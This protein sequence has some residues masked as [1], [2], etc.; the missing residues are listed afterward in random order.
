VQVLALRHGQ[1][2]YNLL[3]LCNDDPARPVHLT[4]LGRR[5][6]SRAGRNLRAWPIER[7]FCS[8]LP[9]AVQTAQLINE[10]LQVTLQPASSLNDI[11]SGFD[12]RPVAEYLAAIAA[13]PVRTAAQG[14]ESWLAY[15]ARVEGFLRRL[16]VQPLRCVAIVAHEETLRVFKAWQEQLNPQ[17]V[18]GLPFGHCEIYPLEV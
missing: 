2:E 3:G 16:A 5:Q 14:G 18:F 17:Q 10:Y 1:S 15:Q 4:E 12:G 13:D 9:R 6:A 7:V 8:R 11:R